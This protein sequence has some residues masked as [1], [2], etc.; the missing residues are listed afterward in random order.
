VLLVTALAGKTFM[1]FSITP[2]FLSSGLKWEPG[3]GLVLLRVIHFPFS[4]PLP[5]RKSPNVSKTFYKLASK[6][7]YLSASYSPGWVVC[8]KWAALPLQVCIFLPLS[9]PVLLTPMSVS[10]TLRGQPSV[11]TTPPISLSLAIAHVL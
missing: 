1:F 11:I 7:S 9:Q 10:P 8:F 5:L 3:A 2:T 6:S 4:F